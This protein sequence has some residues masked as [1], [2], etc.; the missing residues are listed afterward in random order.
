MK[1]E[2]W[3]LV[4]IGTFD[5]TEED[6]MRAGFHGLIDA[7]FQGCEGARQDRQAPLLPSDPVAVAEALIALQPPLPAKTSATG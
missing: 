1:D 3:I 6:D 7:T 5:D 2:R 4:E